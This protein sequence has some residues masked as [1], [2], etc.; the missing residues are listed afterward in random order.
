MARNVE[1]C[2][3]RG[4]FVNKTMYVI[5][6]FDILNLYIEENNQS[7]S[8]RVFLLLVFVMIAPRLVECEHIG[9]GVLATNSELAAPMLHKYMR[10]PFVRWSC[11][12]LWL[13]F[14]VDLNTATER[15]MTKCYGGAS[16]TVDA[17]PSRLL[18]RRW[19]HARRHAQSALIQWTFSVAVL[20]QRVQS[21]SGGLCYSQFE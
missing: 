16:A 17:P 3:L 8:L 5:L 14:I 6:S 13:L 15:D 18:R 19:C 4:K 11:M 10:R 21:R 12:D 7:G 2:L 9:Q 1:A 20:C